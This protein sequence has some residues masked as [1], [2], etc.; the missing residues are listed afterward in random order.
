M[1]ASARG[2]GRAQT[3]WEAIADALAPLAPSDV[4]CSCSRVPSSTTSLNCTATPFCTA[5]SALKDRPM[6]SPGQAASEAATRRESYERAR[7]AVN[8]SKEA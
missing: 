2:A 4:G 5:A 7:R 1:L 6:T 8:A 3:S